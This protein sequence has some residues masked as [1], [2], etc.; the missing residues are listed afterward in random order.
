MTADR[1]SAIVAREY[2][3]I[4]E[5]G[6]DR[7]KVNNSRRAFLGV[8]LVATTAGGVLVAQVQ[9]GGPAAKAGIVPGELIVSVK[10]TATPDPGTLAAALVGLYPGQLVTVSVIRPDGGRQT[11]R[12]TLGQYPG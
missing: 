1:R 9:P 12:G 4:E 5:H 7:A 10:G 11:V 3:A 2:D 6:D 8:D